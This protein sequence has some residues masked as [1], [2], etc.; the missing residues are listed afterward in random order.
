MPLACF[1]IALNQAN[2][3]AIFVS[4]VADN[5]FDLP[6]ATVLIQI[7]AHGGSR[8]QEAQRLG[9]I[10]RAKRGMDAEA[11]NAFFYSLVSQDTMEMQYA[12]KRQRFL[13]N[14][15]YAY[16]VITRLAG[17]ENEPLKLSTKQEQAE[18]LHRVLA[19][20]EEDAMEERLPTD[21]DDVTGLKR[22]ASVGSAVRKASRM[23]SLSGAD[24]AIYMDTSSAASRK[25]K[26]KE[27]HPL[28]RLFR[29]TEPATFHCTSFYYGS[30]F[31]AAH[32]G[33]FDG[34]SRPVLICRDFYNVSGAP[35]F[36]DTLNKLIIR[37]LFTTLKLVDCSQSY[38]II[39]IWTVRDKLL[40]NLQALKRCDLPRVITAT[41]CRSHVA[42]WWV[43]LVDSLVCPGIRTS[44]FQTLALST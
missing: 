21:P 3:P 30:Q 22:T 4:K 42:C 2:V 14:Q 5:S 24:D 25:D 20:T 27:R 31:V 37:S 23:A 18:L 36:D 28:F 41:M 1:S 34:V 12:L 33:V 39:R 38:G 40:K 17:M 19:S 11:Y 35:A 10:L 29:R 6:E 44:T 15:G 26:S 7:S 16:K 43:R 8:R 13:V 9:R 32:F